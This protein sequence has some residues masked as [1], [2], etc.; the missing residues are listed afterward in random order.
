MRLIYHPDAEVE[1]V[2]AAQFYESRVPR[3]GD[4]FLRE[5]DAAVVEIQEAPRRWRIL[6]DGVRRFV[7]KSFPYG[8]YY[9]IEGD[10]LRI[11]VVKHHS[12]HPDYWKSRLDEA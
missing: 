4:R 9:R 1:I 8:I 12:R 2:E 7:M 11:L 10:L 3:L 6:E 5:L